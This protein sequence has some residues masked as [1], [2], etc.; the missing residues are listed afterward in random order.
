LNT[1][2]FRA[3]WTFE[4]ILDY[5]LKATYHAN[6]IDLMA[7]I[8]NITNPAEGLNFAISTR[9]MLTLSTDQVVELH[10]Y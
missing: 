1:S 7:Y 10:L 9:L 8:K 3:D 4:Y 6:N 2:E 5:L